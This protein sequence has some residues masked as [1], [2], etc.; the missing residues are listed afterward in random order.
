MAWGGGG[1]GG[2]EENRKWRGREK[3][4]LLNSSTI[5]ITF[6]AMYIVI[7]LHLLLLQL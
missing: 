2:L 3:E 6:P 1:G 5:S 7:K 4:E